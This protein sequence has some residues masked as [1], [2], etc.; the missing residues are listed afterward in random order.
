MGLDT[1]YG[2]HKKVKSLLSHIF[3]KINYLLFQLNIYVQ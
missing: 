2:M 1:S 3:N